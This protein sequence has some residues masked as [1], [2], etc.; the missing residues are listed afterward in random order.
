MAGVSRGGQ[1]VHTN[2][3]TFA[4]YSHKPC[5]GRT[6][7]RLQTTTNSPSPFPKTTPKGSPNIF[8]SWAYAIRHPSSPGQTSHPM[9]IRM[10]SC[11]AASWMFMK[12]PGRRLNGL[13]YRSL[14]YRHVGRQDSGDI[15]RE[16]HGSTNCCCRNWQGG[17]AIRIQKRGKAKLAPQ[18]ELIWSLPCI[19]VLTVPLTRPQ[20][21]IHS[22]TSGIASM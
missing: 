1:Q 9:P 2:A 8:F 5:G 16:L 11:K 4:Q 17:T 3:P 19:V 12:S 7:C 21:C 15:N 14:G 18:N 22:R 6:E 20:I 10:G 13:K